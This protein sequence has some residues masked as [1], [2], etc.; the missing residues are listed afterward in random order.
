MRILMISWEFPP[1][2]VGGMG[3]HVA[4]LI[5]ALAE[6]ADEEIQ[7]DVLTTRSAGGSVVEQFSKDVTIYRTDIP[8]I[9]PNDLFD[10]V[11]E[12]NYTLL[13]RARRLAEVHAYD[14]IHIHDWLV[15]DVGITLKHEW[16]TPL[17]VTIHATERGRHHSYLPNLMSQQINQLEWRACYEAWRIIVCSGYM[18]GELRGYFN[19]PPD[20]ISVIPNGIDPRPLQS[21]ADQEVQALRQRYAPHGEKLLFFVGRI[22]PEKGIYVLLRAMPLILE[23]MPE[24]RLLV[25]GKNSEQMN[26]LVEELNIGHQVELLGFVSDEQ[27]NCLYSAVDAAIFPSLYEPFGIVAL[28]AMAANCNV[29]ASDVGGLNEVVHH[30]HTGLTIMANN[31]QSICWAVTKLF[32]APEEA[33]QWREKALQQVYSRY[34]WDKIAN[35]TLNLYRLVLKER[36]LVEWL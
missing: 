2:V 10:S 8:P 29:I 35:H 33:A 21:C 6:F 14:L 18:A 20:K 11:L 24:V 25:A 9:D 31:P 16:K 13:Q 5:P 23:T 36:Q 1:F 17:V 26:S 22:T 3:K 19:I 15:A 28:E 12:G 7:I 34:T 30:L 32:S 27:R 4:E